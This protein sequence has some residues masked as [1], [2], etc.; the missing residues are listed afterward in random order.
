MDVML[1]EHGLPAA[2]QREIFALG[3]RNPD[4]HRPQSRSAKA[5]AVLLNS[6]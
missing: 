5:V 3:V 6:L 2:L 1:D 4:L